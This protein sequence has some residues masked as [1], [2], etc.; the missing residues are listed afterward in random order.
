M[1]Q[2]SR[3]HAGFLLLLAAA[4]LPAGIGTAQDKKPQGR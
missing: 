2:A 1:S 4:L 3:R